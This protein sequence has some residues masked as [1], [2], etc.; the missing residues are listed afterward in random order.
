MKSKVAVVILNWNGKKFLAD[1]LP[2]LINSIPS[3]S[4]IYV[5]DNKSSDNSVDY[6]KSTFPSI[7]II[8]NDD[9]Y[10]FAGG[11]NV[12]LNQIEAEYFVLLNSDIEVANNWIEPIINFM[13]SNPNVG[14]CQ[15]K[16]L[17]YFEKDKFEY[18][19]ASGGY[20]DKLGYP[21]CRGRIFQSLE[22][23]N[24]QYNEPI[25]IFWATGACLFV[26][27][28]LYKKLGGL[29]ADFFAHM[30]EI[31]F[32]WRLANKGHKIYCIPESKIYHVG[33]GTLPKSNSRK[34]YLNFRNNLFLLYKN[35]PNNRFY[36]VFFSRLVLDKIA[37]IKFFIDGDIKDGLAVFKAYFSFIKSISSLRKKRKVINPQFFKNVYNGSIVKEHYIGKINNFNELK[38]NWLK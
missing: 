18:A 27:A 6:V 29:D 36:S 24:N 30:E 32:C 38:N 23:D 3:Y 4:C 1:F 26:R 31:D 34:T 33:G 20:I 9:N 37:A 2:S 13:D 35:I 22:T 11:Y 21:F 25:E 12:A 15:P 19:G 17:S 7:N 16:I 14:A 10:G 28:E 5:A 8:I